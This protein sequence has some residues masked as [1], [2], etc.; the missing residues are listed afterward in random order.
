VPRVSPRANKGTSLPERR[1]RRRDQPTKISADRRHQIFLAAATAFQESGYHN[2]N[3][4]EIA[5]RAGLSRAAMYYYFPTKEALVIDLIREPLM[6]NVRQMEEIVASDG[7][8]ADKIERAMRDLMRS[9]DHYSTMNIWFDERFDRILAGSE[10]PDQREVLEAQ[11]HYL[12]LWVRLLAEGQE[13]GE[14]QFAAVPRLITFGVMG[15]IVYTSR[16]YQAGGPLTAEDV[17]AMFSR[18]LLNGLLPR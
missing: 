1:A 3:L 4:A 14:V 18:M 6:A 10:S 9:F 13:R 12:E 8:T 5:E 15:V 7:T 16:W 11:D 17:G 2:V